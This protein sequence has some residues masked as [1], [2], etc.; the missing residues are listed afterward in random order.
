MRK[1]LEFAQSGKWKYKKD[2]KMVE[3]MGTVEQA[4]LGTD[5]EAAAVAQRE[6]AKMKHLE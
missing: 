6:K 5:F 3:R 2:G 4:L 1:L